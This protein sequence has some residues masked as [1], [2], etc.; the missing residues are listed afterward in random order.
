[1]NLWTVGCADPRL[2]AQALS[3]VDSKNAVS[4]M[5]LA[6]SYTPFPKGVTSPTGYKSL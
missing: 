5:N 2:T 6:E 1:V 4:R 3:P